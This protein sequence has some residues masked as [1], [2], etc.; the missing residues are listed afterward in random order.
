MQDLPTA[1]KFL[2]DLARLEARAA[3]PGTTTAE[4]VATCAEVYGAFATVDFSRYDPVAVRQA[5]PELMQRLFDLRISLRNR[6]PAWHVQGLM[7]TDVRRGLRDCFRLLRYANDMLGEHAIGYARIDEGGRTRRGFTGRDMNTLTNRAFDAGEDLPFHAGDVIMV[8]GMAHNSAAIARIGDV[9]SQFS[10]IGIVH[11]DGAGRHWMVESLIED[12]ATINTLE[13]ALDHGIGR[14]VVYRHRDTA[15]AARAAAAIHTHVQRSR[16][17]LG[18]RILYD[19]SMRLDKRRRLFCSKLVRLAFEQAS[20][21]KVQLPT[22]RTR[23]NM[24][25]RDFIERIGVATSETFVPHDMDLEPDFDLVAEWQDYRVTSDLR[26]QDF[27]MDKFF[28]WMD[29]H[30]YHFHESTPIRLISWFGRFAASLSESIKDMIKSVIPKVPI[31]M[32]RK[33][34]AAVAMLHKTAEP[35]YHELQRLEREHIARTGHAMHGRE[36]FEH[37]ERIRA[38]AGNEIGYLRKGG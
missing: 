28:E 33:A 23:L 38:A 26:L 8:R 12:G 19:F 16:S 35:V 4:I 6:I 9:D 24:S 17:G 18:R 11:I 13:H 21:G 7:K 31:H 37:L 5:A 15:L 36:I 30:N 3:S 20:D 27:V 25:N 14:A 22:F 1:A 32:R 2:D 10:H 34:I 29:A